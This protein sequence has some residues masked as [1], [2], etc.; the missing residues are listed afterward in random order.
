MQCLFREFVCVREREGGG[1]EKMSWFIPTNS[2]HSN[3]SR[4]RNFYAGRI[5]F[6]SHMRNKGLNVRFRTLSILDEDEAGERVG[7]NGSRTQWPALLLL[8]TRPTTVWVLLLRDIHDD[9]DH[10]ATIF[11]IFHPR[12]Y[13]I[14]SL[15]SSSLSPFPSSL[16]RSPLDQKTIFP[17]TCANNYSVNTMLAESSYSSLSPSF[18]ISLSLSLRIGFR[19]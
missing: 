11:T 2:P 7:V 14:R 1:G 19:E 10:T 13:T 17:I 12:V 6:P 18:S 15:S 3:P 4:S 5:A 9:D 16:A 8:K